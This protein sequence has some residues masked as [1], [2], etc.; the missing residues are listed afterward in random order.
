MYLKV[1]FKSRT[2]GQNDLERFDSFLK[3]V[4]SGIFHVFFVNA[5]VEGIKRAIKTHTSYKHN[6]SV[7]GCKTYNLPVGSRE[8]EPSG[9]AN[10]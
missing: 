4:K 6:Y 7:N 1:F 10:L 2:I 9:S 3:D 5:K 8:Y